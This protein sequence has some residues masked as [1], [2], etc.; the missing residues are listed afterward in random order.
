MRK[1]NVTLGLWLVLAGGTAQ[2]ATTHIIQVGNTFFNP[3]SPSIARGDTVKWVWA[4]GF[5]T[6]T[7]GIRGA[8]D[9]GA[10]WDRP[11]DSPTHTSYS[12]VFSAEGSFPYFC[13]FHLGMSGTITVTMTTGVADDPPTTDPP[14]TATLAQ[15]LPNPF[16]AETVI[17]YTL[18]SSGHARLVIANILGQSVRQL[19]EETQPAGTYLA[20]WDGRDDMGS[21]VS[22]GVYFYRLETGSVAMTRKMVVL[23]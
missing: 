1:A 16:N 14:T 5:H 2:A 17:P 3:G 8:P 11:I 22:S 12:R 21:P 18:H 15:N 23:R 9:A 6:T 4:S 7:S 19:V 13:Q 10:L 20:R